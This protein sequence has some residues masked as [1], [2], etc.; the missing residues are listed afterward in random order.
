M[1]SPEP[2]KLYQLQVCQKWIFFLQYNRSNLGMRGIPDQESLIISASLSIVSSVYP[3]CFLFV[4]LCDR[5]QE[6]LGRLC[7]LILSGFCLLFHDQLITTHQNIICTLIIQK[8]ISCSNVINVYFERC[9][10]MYVVS[11]KVLTQGDLKIK[12]ILENIQT[13]MY[14]VIQLGHCQF[15]R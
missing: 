10:M 5:I 15:P 12:T 13:I 4:S 1:N 2:L 6:V 11:S 14:F 7:P 3:V 8:D 9:K